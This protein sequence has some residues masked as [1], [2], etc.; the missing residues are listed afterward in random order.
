MNSE[1]RRHILRASGHTFEYLG[2]GPG[3]YSTGL[4]Q[5]QDR[6]L[7][8]EEQFLSQSQGPNGGAVVYTGMNDLVTSTLVTK[9][10]ILRMV[11]RQHSIFQFQQPLVLQMMQVELQLDLTLSLIV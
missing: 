4:T 2:F 5:K 1:K 10:S 7:S 6:V 9:S 11:L 8:R 3:N